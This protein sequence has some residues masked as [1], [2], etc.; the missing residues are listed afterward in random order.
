MTHTIEEHEPTPEFYAALEREVIETLHREARVWPRPRTV[1]AL[2]AGLLLGAALGLA[3]TQVADA[4]QRREIVSATGA[5]RELAVVQR[6]LARDN[7][8]QVGLAA[9]RGA[10]P[11]ASR[12]AAEVELRAREAR[13]TR[14][15]LDLAE[16]QETAAPPRDELWAPRV[17]GRD[18]VTER[19]E[20]D[21]RAAAVLPDKH[22]AEAVAQRLALRKRFLAE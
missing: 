17:G 4:R 18:F 13:L 10:I 2:A 14:I 15:D 16:A 3:S 20:I 19:L 7:Y 9:E 11:P 1:V 21:A 22:E 8:V 6:D 12:R 5:K